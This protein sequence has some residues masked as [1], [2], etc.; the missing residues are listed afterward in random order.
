MRGRPGSSWTCCAP[1]PQV[2]INAAQ[3]S[4][5]NPKPCTKKN[6]ERTE[7]RTEVI[8]SRL[9][10]RFDDDA[11]SLKVIPVDTSDNKDV[12]LQF[13][14]P[15]PQATSAGATTPLEQPMDRRPNPVAETDRW[16]HAGINE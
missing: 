2:S 13:P 7:A 6:D 3:S 9:L 16:Y 11:L 14:A 4:E 8:T 5:R 12:P 1:E 15:I 10:R